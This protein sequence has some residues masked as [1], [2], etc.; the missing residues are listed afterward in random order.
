MLIFFELVG[1]LLEKMLLSAKILRNN[2]Q[3]IDI[4][5]I[6]IRSESK[7]PEDFHA[8]TNFFKVNNL[9]HGSHGDIFHPSVD[10]LSQLFY[11]LCFELS[12]LKCV[13]IKF[14][15][16]AL[17]NISVFLILFRIASLADN[18]MRILKLLEVFIWRQI[19]GF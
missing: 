2:T 17:N 11:D 18:L 8:K 14:W 10:N 13:I 4:S 9:I 6:T 7:A 19:V 12:K 3:N 16:N 5:I 15:E 1:K